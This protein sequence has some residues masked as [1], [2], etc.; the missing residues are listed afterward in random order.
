MRYAGRLLFMQKPEIT[1][2]VKTQCGWSNGVRAV[3]KKYDLAYTEK[4]IIQ[5]P[6]FRPPF[7]DQ[8]E[9]ASD[10]AALGAMLPLGQLLDGLALDT[11]STMMLAGSDAYAYA[12]TV[13]N[14]IKYLAANKQPGAQ[15]AYEELAKRFPGNPGGR[16]PKPLT[17]VN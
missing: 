15:A 5:N 12:L 3:L 16:P 7:G 13:Y 11:D 2:Y 6:A 17:D 10:V 9:F 1:A 4:D 8:T 14:Y